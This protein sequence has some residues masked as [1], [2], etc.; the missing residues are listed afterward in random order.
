MLGEMKTEARTMRYAL[1]RGKL[2]LLEYLNGYPT[3]A[4]GSLKKF[5]R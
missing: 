3:I 4:T 2:G 5:T 1:D